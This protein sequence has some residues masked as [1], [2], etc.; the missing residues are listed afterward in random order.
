MKPRAAHALARSLP[1][2]RRR[3][4]KVAEMA[5]AQLAAHL[6]DVRDSVARFEARLA[7]GP[8]AAA[9]TPVP[10]TPAPPPPPLEPT[11]STGPSSQ[12]PRPPPFAPPQMQAAKKYNPLERATPRGPAPAPPS[13]S[14]PAP[15]SSYPPATSPPGENDDEEDELL[16][17]L[18][19]EDRTPPPPP[20]PPSLPPDSVAPSSSIAAA[21]ARA[22]S[23]A[24]PAAPAAGPSSSP[25]G[26]HATRGSET[27][28]QGKARAP[29]V[30]LRRV[31]I[32]ARLIEKFEELAQPNTSKNKET[33]GILAGTLDG[34]TH[35][36]VKSIILPKQSGTSDTCDT[37]PD[38]M[39]YI[40][41]MF[42]RD[43]KVLGCIHTHP[44]Q[45]CFLSSIDQHNLLGYQLQLPEAVSI[46]IAPSFKEDRLG[47]FRLTQ[48]GVE[49]LLRCPKELAFK[50]HEHEIAHDRIYH[51]TTH[52]EIVQGAVGAD[53]VEAIDLRE[54][55]GPS[56]AD[57]ASSSSS[58]AA[59][60]AP[61]PSG[62]AGA[63]NP[64]GGSGPPPKRAN[65]G[66]K[67]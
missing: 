7:R 39:D 57:K 37:D 31:R 41:L 35:F 14:A 48:E 44:S 21:P 23:S 38:E 40:N 55:L 18:L 53:M 61:G 47:A 50:F 5:P 26:L 59:G 15:P 63:A 6:R 60:P 4:A 30:D 56:Y 2:R 8:A 9:P 13:S 66:G 29:D 58:R 24:P 20:P 62:A 34:D 17:A 19:L 43:W 36:T 25:T 67:A 27:A 12:P 51:R 42:E 45:K 32:A 28:P 16:A 52:C 11:R 46:V 10:P 54:R 22:A 1:R 49:C 64:K 33:C 3:E 65:R